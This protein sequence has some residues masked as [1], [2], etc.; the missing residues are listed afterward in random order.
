MCLRNA[1]T[2]PC[3]FHSLV[4]RVMRGP[5]ENG[6]RLDSCTAACVCGSRKKGTQ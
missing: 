6:L 1:K 3:S 4:I 5:C 2:G